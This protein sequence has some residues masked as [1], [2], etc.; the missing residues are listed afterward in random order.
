MS[1]EMNDQ[2]WEGLPSLTWVLAL[3]LTRVTVE[4]WR[5]GSQD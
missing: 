4:E 1:G 3:V 2:K 5:K